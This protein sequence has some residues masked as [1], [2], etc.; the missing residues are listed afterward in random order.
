MFS[1]SFLPIVLLLSSTPAHAVVLS[2]WSPGVSVEIDPFAPSYTPD[3]RP[4]WQWI[5]GGVDA[6]GYFV[7]GYWAPISPN[8][9]YLWAPGYWQGRSYYEGYWR[10]EVQVGNAWVGGYYAGGRYVNAR[11]VGEREAARAEA[12]ADAQHR[13]EA[14]RRATSARHVEAQR[15]ENQR[16]DAER[17]AHAK[18][19]DARPPK[20]K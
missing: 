15:A 11:W 13:A 18:H 6:Y 1:L 20:R 4:D 10:P 17:S 7:P 16:R 3:P 12:H 9:G 5:P 2:V 8:P 14:A 19:H